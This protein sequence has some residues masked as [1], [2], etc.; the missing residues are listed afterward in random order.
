MMKELNLI[1]WFCLIISVLMSCERPAY[2]DEIRDTYQEAKRNSTSGAVID[3][4]MWSAISL[5]EFD[6]DEAVSY[7][8]QLDELGHYD[9]RLPT[10]SELRTL[11]QNCP[12][13]ETYGFCN[14]TDECLE[15]SVAE[16]DRSKDTFCYSDDCS[17]RYLGYNSEKYEDGYYSRLGDNEP[18]WSSTG[19]WYSSD[20]ISVRFD[21][22]AISSEPKSYSYYVRC[23]RKD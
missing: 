21:N 7:C 1:L 9:W 22:A 2:S 4:N 5:Y 11:I 20:A 14:M 13:T 16:G 18:L 19:T 23:V 17:C 6:W 15:E 12:D 8:E 3:D 10:V